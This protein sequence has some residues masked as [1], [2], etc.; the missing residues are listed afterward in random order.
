MMLKI[1]KTPKVMINS[2][3][4]KPKDLNIFYLSIF[5]NF[6]I[7]SALSENTIFMLIFAKK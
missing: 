2:I 5:I 7:N 4:V 3:K 1:A 6:F